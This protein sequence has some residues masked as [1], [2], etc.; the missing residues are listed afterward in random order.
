MSMFQLLTPNLARDVW[1]INMSQSVKRCFAVYVCWVFRN[2]ITILESFLSLSSVSEGTESDAESRSQHQTYTKE[3]VP[4]SSFRPIAIPRHPMRSILQ[5]PPSHF[6]LQTNP[7]LPSTP[8]KST[9]W[10]V[11]RS[12]NFQWEGCSEQR[13]I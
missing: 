12:M 4:V 5:S 13:K 9:T 6:F 10:I 7:S 1:R 11:A 3:W 2:A 8:K